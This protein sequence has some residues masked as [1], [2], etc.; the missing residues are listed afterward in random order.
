MTSQFDRL[1]VALADRYA[2]QQEI[3]TGG[4]ATVYLAEDL[5]HHRKV[6]VKVM[7]PELAAALGTER[8]LREIEIAAGL[9]HPHI[10]PLHDSGQADGLLYY[11]MPYV[12]GESLRDRLQR[13]KQLAIDEALTITRE[14]AEALAYAHARGIVHRDIKPAN[15]M[16]EAGHAVVTDFGVAHVVHNMAADRLT[17]T[18][19][20]PGTPQYM[21]PEQGGGEGRVDGRSDVY[22]LGCVLYEMLVGDPPFTGATAQAIVAR[23]MVEAVPRPRIVRDT[24]S[25]SLENVTLKALARTPA[26]RFKT[27]V[28]LA[29]ALAAIPA[30]PAYLAPADLGMEARESGITVTPRRRRIGIVALALAGGA[31]LLTVIGFLSTRVYDLKLQIPAQ[32]TPSRTDFPIVGLQALVLPLVFCFV[33]IAGFVIVKFL[34]RFSMYGLGR[35]PAIGETLETWPRKTYSRWRGFWG[36][37]QPV[38]IAEIFLIAATV[39]AII[40]LGL[41]RDFLAAMWT[42]DTAVLGCSSRPLYRAYVFSMAVLILGLSLAWYRVFRYLGTRPGGSGGLA[43]TRWVGLAG[44]VMLVV[45]LT[46]PWRLVYD[47]QAERTLL[48]G[49]RGYILME[50]DGYLVIHNAERRSTTSYRIGEE[51]PMERQGTIGYVFEEAVAFTGQ[52]PGC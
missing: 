50:K 48:N 32:F 44:I 3:G 4:M 28:D 5:K 17:A 10:L 52:A 1:K 34:M 6:A 39:V 41:F 14:V 19:L 40:V 16:L 37:V 2:I 23:K 27:A 8:F 33:V 26:D 18:G 46:L 42:D 30:E 49:E 45:V 36:T 21:S 31:A 43:V 12:E 20:S 29:Q 51:P 7:R 22:S 15:I 9:R 13:E 35:L 38:T 47:N 25:E 11:V 24:V